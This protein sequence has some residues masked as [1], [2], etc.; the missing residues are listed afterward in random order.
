MSRVSFNTTDNRGL[1]TKVV[2][3]NGAEIINK[4]EIRIDKYQD[5][6]ESF[7][8]KLS[9]RELSD[10]DSNKISQLFLSI[11]DYEKNT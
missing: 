8:Q 11:S 5:T 6:L 3:N 1:R 7:L 2:D 10:E 9:G 4:N